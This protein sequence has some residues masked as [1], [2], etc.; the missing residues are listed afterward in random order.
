MKK[1][2]LSLSL[3]GVVTAAHAEVPNVVTSIKPLHSLV[4]QVMD[5][6]GE[7]VLLMTQGSPHGYQMKPSDAKAIAGADLV[8]YVDDHLETFLPDVLEKSGKQ[9]NVIEWTAVP[10]VALLKTRIGGMWP[11]HDHG[12]HDHDHDHEHE[13]DHDHDH[14]HDHGDHDH[15]HGD[16]DHEHGDHDHE[17][18]DHEHHHHDHGEFDLHVWLD[19]QN[20][21]ALVNAVA[22]ALSEA[23]P[24]HAEQYAANA[25]A[26]KENIANVNAEIN[27]QLGSVAGKPFM[28]FHDAY[29][30]FEQAHGLNAVGVV[31]VSPEHEPGAA[32]IGE[33][34]N[35]L[36]G[37]RVVCL[38]NEP[39]FPSALTA[40][41]VDGTNVHTGTLDPIGADLQAG[42]DLYGELLRNLSQN[43]YDCLSK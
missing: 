23:D 27:D 18:G 40:K 41:L 16:H 21:T 36:E 34:R 7:P 35:V 30:Y 31:R 43:L 42:P 13:H 1:S 28:S 9:T 4:A 38:F 22:D 11:P 17:H 2:I 12:D 10:D 25:E 33:I 14:D 6:V 39:Q 8:V 29:Q 5:G 3:L 20:S 15:E 26:A 24:E 32:R 19:P 37:E